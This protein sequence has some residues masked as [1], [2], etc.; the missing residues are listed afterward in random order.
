MLR[1]INLLLRA[2]HAFGVDFIG[3]PFGEIFIT[4]VLRAFF[5]R[6]LALF[7]RCLRILHERRL[8]LVFV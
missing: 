6:F 3:D 1:G 8:N 2:V 4:F 5:L 7:L